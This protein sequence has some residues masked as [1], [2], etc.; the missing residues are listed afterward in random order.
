[1]AG[2]SG[3]ATGGDGIT[4]VEDADLNIWMA[5]K[6]RVQL[7]WAQHT[8]WPNETFEPTDEPFLAVQYMP[9]RVVKVTIDEPKSDRTGVLLL[10]YVVQVGAATQSQVL[11]QAGRIADF[12]ASGVKVRFEDVCVR[13]DEDPE[14]LGGYRDGGYWHTPIR[15]KWRCYA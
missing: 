9:G 4:M 2:D 1:M 6:Q 7:A 5:L 3:G 8:A 11:Y 12:F 13:I 15:I 14:V 10:R